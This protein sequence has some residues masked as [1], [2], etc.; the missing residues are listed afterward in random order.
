MSAATPDATMSARSVAR[1]SMTS[2]SDS[3]CGSIDVAVTPESRIHAEVACLDPE[4]PPPRGSPRVNSC[5]GLRARR[6]AMAAGAKSPRSRSATRTSGSGGRA[7]QTVSS[8]SSRALAAFRDRCGVAG[9]SAARDRRSASRGGVREA[10]KHGAGE[11]C[12]PACRDQPDR[13]SRKATTAVRTSRPDEDLVAAEWTVHLVHARCSR[14]TCWLRRRSQF[15]RSQNAERVRRRRA[16]P[17]ELCE[18]LPASTP[19]L[20]GV[21]SSS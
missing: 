11:P 18:L 5:V 17:G 9:L 10:L 7:T 6:R 20:P 12:A 14:S 21:R 19:V 3:M 13:C 15:A 16:E 2:S 4:R 8:T 1:G